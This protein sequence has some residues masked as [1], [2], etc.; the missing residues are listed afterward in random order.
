MF[1]HTPSLSDI[2]RASP[3][4]IP[5]TVH[6]LP[7]LPLVTVSLLT[8]PLVTVPASVATRPN[9]RSSVRAS[10][11]LLRPSSRFFRAKA[12]GVAVIR[13]IGLCDRT[14]SLLFPKEHTE[15]GAAHNR[16]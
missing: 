12:G 8:L 5:I 13:S 4:I 15:R 2:L 16:D 14:F 6:T 3:T 1:S 10:T 9:V 7:T 11:A